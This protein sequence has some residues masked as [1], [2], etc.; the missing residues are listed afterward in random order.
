M[1][2]LHSDYWIGKHTLGPQFSQQGAS[3]S[4]EVVARSDQLADGMVH[5]FS[6]KPLIMS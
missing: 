5:L 1:D 6:D 4:T 2:S 3:S